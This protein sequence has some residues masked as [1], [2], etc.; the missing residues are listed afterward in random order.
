[1]LGCHDSGLAPYSPR[2]LA[3]TSIV[4]YSYSKW[5][6]AYSVWQSWLERE[7]KP[8]MYSEFQWAREARSMNCGMCVLVTLLHSTA[9][10]VASC[11]F[12]TMPTGL[13]DEILP[14]IRQ[15]NS[16]NCS[17]VMINI[18]T[19]KSLAMAFFAFPLCAHTNL[20][21]CHLSRELLLLIKPNPLRFKV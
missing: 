5:K 6:P 18:P 15:S 2:P 9:K 21:Q 8:F 3:A 4:N 10:C 16:I 20:K 14:V 13:L 12:A 17:E 19:C 11:A 7:Y 1:M